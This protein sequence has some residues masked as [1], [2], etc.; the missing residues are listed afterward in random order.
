MV[1]EQRISIAKTEATLQTCSA[2]KESS[3]NPIGLE[4]YFWRNGQPQGFRHLQIDR[5]LDL[6][7]H[8]YRDLRRVCPFENLVH[9]ARCLPEA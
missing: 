3:D 8:L 4:Q 5:K 1:L 7:V 9:Q 2:L 6:R